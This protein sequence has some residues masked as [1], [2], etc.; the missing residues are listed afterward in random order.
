MNASVE[1]SKQ[2]SS[3]IIVVII[4]IIAMLLW[5]FV[6]QNDTAPKN[7][8]ADNVAQSSNQTSRDKDTEI[9]LASPIGEQQ[10]LADAEI[11]NATGEDSL[12]DPTVDTTT[13]TST[14]LSNVITL[15][16]LDES[17]PWLQEK[18]ESMTWR[19]ELLKLIID[20]DMIRRFVVFVDNF[21]QGQLAYEHSPLVRPDI[22][23]TAQPSEK[24]TEKGDKVWL[25]D[26]R[27][28]RRFSLYID[29]LRSFDSENLIEW[30]V[31]LK[32]LIDDAYAELGY[33]DSDFTPVLQA[34]ITRVL[35]R[36]IPA[37]PI[38]LIRPSVMYRYK[39][40]DIESLS[41]ADKLLLRLGKENLLVLKSVLLEMSEKLARQD[42]K[43]AK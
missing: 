11:I 25:W 6:N 35:D 33:P 23:F 43:I 40:N 27:V 9:N 34:A 14:E 20:D 21:A 18:L 15:P 13:D 32:P 39:N 29:L 24:T 30:Y 7:V 17:D 1:T 8:A 10:E 16:T 41:D 19:K 42:S 26:E 36:E 31:Q 5:Y 28:T 4:L 12:S 37:Q 3:S 22:K 2:S 38:E